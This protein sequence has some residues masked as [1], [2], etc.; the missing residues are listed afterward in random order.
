MRASILTLGLLLITGLLLPAVLNAEG[1]IPTPAP[2]QAAEPAAPAEAGPA[3]APQ[4]AGTPA[5]EGQAAVLAEIKKL[6]DK[7][8]AYAS[9]E[10][11]QDQRIAKL[12]ADLAQL[13]Q[14]YYDTYVKL[15]ETV[16]ATTTRDPAGKPILNLR[17]LV[18]SREGR[19]ELA[20]ALEA[21]GVLRDRGT[22]LV[23]NRMPTRQTLKVN[24]R[25]YDVN[26]DSTLSIDV[27]VGTVTTQL[28]GYEAP[29]N[30]TVCAPSYE[31]RVIIG[32]AA[33]PPPTVP[34]QWYWNWDP[35]WGWVQVS[36]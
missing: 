31:Q 14:L 20:S 26:A 16:N 29:K 5:D 22:L 8:D 35:V 10:Q 11:D 32:P 7:I 9:A 3:A 18:S 23:E 25:Y 36:Y 2:A 33:S 13:K 34:Q 4:P 28:V 19:E 6:S 24:A 15:E 1:P 27:P 21:P 17:G 30:W 12:E